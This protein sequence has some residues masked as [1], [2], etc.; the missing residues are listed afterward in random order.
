[1]A[2][3]PRPQTE[4]GPGVSPVATL[5]MFQGIRDIAAD[6]VAI[7]L[8][9]KNPLAELKVSDRAHVLAA[10]ANHGTGPGKGFVQSPHLPGMLVNRRGDR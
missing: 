2:R 1:M 3:N 8:V 6:G 7:V 4:F 9:E 10:V 5:A